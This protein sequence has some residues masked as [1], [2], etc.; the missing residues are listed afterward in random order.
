LDLITN[1]GFSFSNKIIIAL[2]AGE[3]QGLVGSAALATSYVNNGVPVTA[4]VNLDMI[5]YPDRTLPNTIFWM[6]R[7]TTPS[8]TTLALDLTKTYL[9]DSQLTS[10][11]TGCCSDQQSFHSRGFPAVGVFEARSATNNPNYHQSSDL[12]PTITAAHLLRNAK[13][14]FALITTLAE[15]TG[16]LKK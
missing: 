7:S 10:T 11:T 9:G 15:I 1:E 13:S 12:P 3:E 16:P 6:S 8:L 4:M 5:G 14:A 2:F